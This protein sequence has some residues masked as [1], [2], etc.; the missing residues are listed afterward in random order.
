LPLNGAGCDRLRGGG[1]GRKEL[2][3]VSRAVPLESS[4]VDRR[5]QLNN[6]VT[7]NVFFLIFNL[8]ISRRFVTSNKM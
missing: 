1:W 7:P 2:L 3:A 6:D 8:L 4:V 5:L